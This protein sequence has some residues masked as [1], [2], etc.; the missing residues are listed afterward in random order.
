M[1]PNAGTRVVEAE[2]VLLENCRPRVKWGSAHMFE[3][4]SNSD[5]LIRGVS[6]FLA[7]YTAVTHSNYGY[8]YRRSFQLR[9]T[10]NSCRQALFHFFLIG[11]N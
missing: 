7:L 10:E 3:L 6:A 11:R 5:G 1:A 9:Y 8:T 2:S 4:D